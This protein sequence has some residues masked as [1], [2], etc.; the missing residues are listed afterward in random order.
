MMAAETVQG[1]D[2]AEI[3]AWWTRCEQYARDFFV[4]MVYARD[5]MRRTLK[6]SPTQQKHISGLIELLEEARKPLLL[7]RVK[8]HQQAPLEEL[9]NHQKRCSLLGKWAIAGL[10]VYDGDGTALKNFTEL[11]LGPGDHFVGRIKGVP[12]HDPIEK[13]PLLSLA[14]IEN[15]LNGLRDWRHAHNPQAW[16]AEVTR[17]LAADEAKQQMPPKHTVQ[18]GEI[19]GTL[20]ES[21]ELAA[22]IEEHFTEQS[23]AAVEKAAE[24]DPDL[25]AYVALRKKGLKHKGIRNQLGWTKS[26][27]YNVQ[28]RFLRLCNKVRDRRVG[29]EL[30]VVTSPGF[31]D[32]SR[33]TEY[34]V[35]EDGKFGSAPPRIGSHRSGGGRGVW[36]HR[37]SPGCS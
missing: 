14:L 20:A 22:T 33:F 1:I 24:A 13:V 34:E 10:A 36:K 6:L 3:M 23:L 17:N 25:T 37:Q 21:S 7:C 28:V 16:V 35:L 8:L 30:K 9:F 19:E 5:R 31:S 2:I 18:L 27:A 15:H 12:V 4:A 11:A 29:V 26:H 32:S